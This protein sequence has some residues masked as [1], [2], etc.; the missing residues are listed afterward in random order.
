MICNDGR[1]TRAPREA[2][3]RTGEAPNLGRKADQVALSGVDSALKSTATPMEMTEESHSWAVLD[4]LHG[5]HTELTLL[6]QNTG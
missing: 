2:W 4:H 6:Q 3:S 1:E 5:A